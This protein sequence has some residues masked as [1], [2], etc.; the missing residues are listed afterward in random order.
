MHRYEMLLLTVPEITEDETRSLESHLDRLIKEAKGT[1][2]SFERWGKYRLAYPIRKNDYGIYFLIRFEVDESQPLLDNIH[3]LL[4]VK[5][6]DIAMR[7]MVTALST[8]ES[9]AYQRPLSLEETP[10]RDVDSFL[11]EHKMEGLISSM[12]TKSSP[13]RPEKIE[14]GELKKTASPAESIEKQE[15]KKE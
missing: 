5:L 4:T 12:K 3:S 8:K 13:A 7:N 2:I 9:L 1:I 11:K 6:S 14:V 15:A 10:S